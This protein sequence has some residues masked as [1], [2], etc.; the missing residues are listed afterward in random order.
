MESEG[1]DQGVG[2]DGVRYR[3]STRPASGVANGVSSTTEEAG[4]TDAD[5]W[6]GM[7]KSGSD[8]GSDEHRSTTTGAANACSDGSDSDGGGLGKLKSIG[9][10]ETVSG[11]K[12]LCAHI[13][14]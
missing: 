9:S 12:N 5:G 7:S 3:R 13:S 6:N 8:S 2:G 10:V 4:V 14:G 11:T 1:M